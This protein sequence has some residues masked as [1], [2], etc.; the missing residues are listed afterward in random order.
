[1]VG[2]GVVGGVGGG[3]QKIKIRE[4]TSG[5]KCSAKTQ[6]SKLPPTK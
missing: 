3:A 1:M 5:G 2:N 4:L 6:S